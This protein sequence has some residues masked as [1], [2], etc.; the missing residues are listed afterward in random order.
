MLTVPGNEIPEYLAIRTS[1]RIE[2]RLKW[3]LAARAERTA[4]WRIAKLGGTFDFESLQPFSSH[5]RS[6]YLRYIYFTDDD[7]KHLSSCQSL[8]FVDAGRTKVTDIGAS[9]LANTR[10]LGYLFLWGTCVSDD[11]VDAIGN[12]TWL[13]M[14]DVSET[15][16]SRTAF[17]AL[18]MRFPNCLVSHSEYG[19]YFR[20]FS[21]NAALNEFASS[22]ESQH[23]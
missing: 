7:M 23:A 2:C 20:E 3:P 13:R 14:L 12:M 16:V 6:V 4:C 5:V 9:Y 10:S 19:Q 21:G 17:D 18:R 15:R 1:R 11:L 8:M 22:D